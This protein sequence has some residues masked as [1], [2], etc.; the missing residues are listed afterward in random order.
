MTSNQDEF[1]PANFE[2]SATQIYSLA[3]TDQVIATSAQKPTFQDL[4]GSLS[5]ENVKEW[6]TG[7]SSN[8]STLIWWS[9][10]LLQESL[11]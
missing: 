10:V 9:N 8:T 3:V 4:N 2:T 1:I 11:L 7:K 5:E 6:F